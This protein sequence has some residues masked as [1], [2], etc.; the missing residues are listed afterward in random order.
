MYKIGNTNSSL[1]VQLIDAAVINNFYLTDT[2][3]IKGPI[4]II[5]NDVFIQKCNLGPTGQDAIT[6]PV[7]VNLTVVFWKFFM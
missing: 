3:D 7:K 5:I 2:D 4:T 6:D 1:D